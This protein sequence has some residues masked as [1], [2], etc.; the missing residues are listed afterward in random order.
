M[1]RRIGVLCASA[2]AVASLALA[3]AASAAPTSFS[4]TL[5]NGGC[6]TARSVT[7]SGPSRIDA[8][9]SSTTASPTS[10]YVEILR[11]D[12]GVAANGSYDTPGAGVYS[13]R[14]CKWYEG[15]DPP[16][17]QYTARY[18]TG[19]AGQPALPQAQA[20][21]LGATATV[22]N[23][24]HGSGAVTT[25][26][27]L[28]WFTITLN[29]QGLGTVKVF[30]PV[31]RTHLLFTGAAVR[32]GTGTVRITMGRMTLVLHHAGAAER[33]SFLSPHFRTSGKVVRGGFV[34]V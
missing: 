25:R 28:A 1:H 16:T 4:G 6:D 23:S 30:D 10:V 33:V 15:M 34:V 12:G 31:R 3:G 32:F 22:S 27:G 24:I 11:P 5:P 18:A 14:V 29:S 26:S 8:D 20:G 21:V 9:V 7:V 2:A 13:V 17:I 19:P